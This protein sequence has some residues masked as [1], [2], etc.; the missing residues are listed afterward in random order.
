MTR[1]KALVEDILLKLGRKPS[2][3]APQHSRT[4]KH[5]VPAFVELPELEDDEDYSRS[6][7][8]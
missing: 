5:R 3:P 1:I 6:A 2:A 4:A 8:N 7:Y